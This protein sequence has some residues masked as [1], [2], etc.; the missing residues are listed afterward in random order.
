MARFL[1]ATL[2]LRCSVMSWPR[3]SWERKECIPSTGP[4][5]PRGG[6]PWAGRSTWEDLCHLWPDYPHRLRRHLPVDVILKKTM[7]DCPT[8]DKH[9]IFIPPSHVGPQLVFLS[10]RLGFNAK[11]AVFTGDTES[12][13]ASF[14]S[15]LL[16]L[17]SN[18]NFLIS[19]ERFV[20][21]STWRF[22]SLWQ[23]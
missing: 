16:L 21:V 19:S 17:C 9:C 2:V 3:V 1:P 6:G 12:S 8:L 20:T 10:S 18:P 5:R 11:W 23:A 14:L 22:S 7:N 15:S 13:P 4:S